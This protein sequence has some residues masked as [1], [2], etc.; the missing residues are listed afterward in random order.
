MPKTRI[1]T[2]ALVGLRALD[3]HVLEDTLLRS[4]AVV[5]GGQGTPRFVELLPL[6]ESR[7]THLLSLQ[8]SAGP[9][10]RSSL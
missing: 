10:P 7:A 3:P 5:E 8:E 2:A 1:I 6:T 4:G 9:Q